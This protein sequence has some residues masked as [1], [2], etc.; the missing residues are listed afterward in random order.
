MEIFFHKEYHFSLLY[1]IMK[2]KYCRILT[3]A[4]NYQQSIFI[5]ILSL[6]YAI[7]KTYDS[8]FCLH[9]NP[10]LWTHSRPLHQSSLKKKKNLLQNNSNFQPLNINIYLSPRSGLHT[11]S[12]WKTP[13][14]SKLQPSFLHLLP[15][16]IVI[17]CLGA[18][19]KR[20]LSFC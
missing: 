11:F 2:K 12:T 1:G 5:R 18:P 4:E 17:S 14:Y 7:S 19:R 15:Y 3:K 8:K 6:S 10:S 20:A 13:F 9:L 16:F